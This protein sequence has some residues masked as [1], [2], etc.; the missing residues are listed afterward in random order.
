MASAVLK[1]CA[2]DEKINVLFNMKVFILDPKM[3]GINLQQLS[4]SRSL[5]PDLAHALREYL[6]S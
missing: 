3:K 5:L 1:V 4:N 2:D 6:A